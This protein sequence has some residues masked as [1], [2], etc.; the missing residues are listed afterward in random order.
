MFIKLGDFYFNQDEV[1]A[2]KKI[3]GG[4]R[5]YVKDRMTLEIATVSDEDW[6]TFKRSFSVGNK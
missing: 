6:E 1:V 5:V 4:A 2:V 3:G